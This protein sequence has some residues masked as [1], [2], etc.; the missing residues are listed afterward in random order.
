MSLLVLSSCTENQQAR[1]W[2]GT[3]TIELET[4]QR[5]VNAT[6][7]DTDLWLLTKTD[8]TRPTVYEFIEKS[9]WGVM[10]GKIKIKE[11]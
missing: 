2:G 7:K 4:N 1:R 10:N 9:N 8:S 11:K 6:W 5:L 3:E